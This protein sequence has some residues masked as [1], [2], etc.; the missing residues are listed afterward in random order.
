MIQL[1]SVHDDSSDHDGV[2]VL[3]DSV[4]PR[5]VSRERTRLDVWMRDVAPSAPLFQWFS[6][7]PAKWQEFVS[8]YHRE[9]E[10]KDDFIR[11]L[12]AQST[13]GSLTLVH[14][15]PYPLYNSAAALKMY[16]ERRRPRHENNY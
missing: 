16:L 9:L 6:H 5:R 13:N 14:G 15:S 11:E 4:W 7:D 3:V 12:M 2:R 10:Q 1:K 8:R